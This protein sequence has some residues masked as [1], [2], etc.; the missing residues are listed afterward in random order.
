MYGFV[1]ENATELNLRLC[2]YI[3]VTTKVLDLTLH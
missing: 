3:F 1:I 2:K